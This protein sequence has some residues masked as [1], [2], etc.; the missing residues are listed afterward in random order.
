[1]LAIPD[2]FL[3]C[4]SKICFANTCS[5]LGQNYLNK[6]GKVKTH[7]QSTKEGGI[8]LKAKN[9][10]MAHRFTFIIHNLKQHFHTNKIRHQKKYRNL[11][12]I[13]S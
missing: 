10:R 8:Y 7:F 2:R 1:M 4:K 9:K 13:D 5:E 6:Y 12:Q 11:F 3:L